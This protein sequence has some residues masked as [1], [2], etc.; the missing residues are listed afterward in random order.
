ML[1]VVKVCSPGNKL[2]VIYGRLHYYYGIWIINTWQLALIEIVEQGQEQQE[3]QTTDNN[4][5]EFDDLFNLTG[6]PDRMCDADLAP[7]NPQTHNFENAQASSSSEVAYNTSP[8]QSSKQFRT[9]QSATTDGTGELKQSPH[10]HNAD[11]DTENTDDRTF[12]EAF[13]AYN[14]GPQVELSQPY[15]NQN[16]MN[17]GVTQDLQTATGHSASNVYSSSPPYDQAPG[18]PAI[19]RPALMTWSLQNDPSCNDGTV[20]I[21]DERQNYKD[22]S[23]TVTLQFSSSKE[24]SDYRP[25]RRP[26]PFD[27][28]I[29]RTTYERQECVIKLIKAMR[30]FEC[31]TDNWGM[32]K[33]FATKKFSDRK[34]EICCWNILVRLSY[35]RQNIT[36]NWL[37]LGLLYCA[38]RSWAFPYTR[39]RSFEKQN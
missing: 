39:R 25:D 23:D 26:M 32:I 7:K 8:V 13:A 6:S 34:I 29:P 30:S 9:P 16:N 37:L 31:A 14:A 38:T 19:A 4:L 27:P 1:K 12:Y 17:P 24:A 20:E 33:P 28:T 36:L 2:S 10:D 21:K 35:I 5:F 11:L 15:S 22:P 18:N 3:H